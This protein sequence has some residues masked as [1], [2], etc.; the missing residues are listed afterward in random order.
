[1]ENKRLKHR[2]AAV[3]SNALRLGMPWCIS[4]CIPEYACSFMLRRAAMFE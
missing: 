4:A 1:M 2:K 3:H